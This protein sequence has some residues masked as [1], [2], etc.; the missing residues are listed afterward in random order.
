MF[1]Y[2]SRHL[3]RLAGATVFALAG[4]PAHAQ[5]NF[6]GNGQSFFVPLYTSGDPLVPPTAQNSRFVSL[7][8][9]G[10]TQ[11]YLVDTG[12]L[13]LVTTLNTYYVPG[14][15]VQVGS[16]SI[17]YS[18][19]GVNPTGPIYLT[20]VTINGA[21]GQSVVARVPVLASN[22]TTT[23]QMGIGFDRGGIQFNN[24]T[25][26][27]SSYNPNPLLGLVSGPAA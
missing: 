16:G 15:D 17:T 26:L 13:G 25:P 27:S 9:S 4:V 24:G 20:N 11:R 1:K 23:S 3:A 21:N 10:I 7:S 12:S 6:Y 8:L 18:T 19:S 22:T 5:W 14:N 2:S